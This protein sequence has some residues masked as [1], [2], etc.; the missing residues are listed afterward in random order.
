M[1][2]IWVPVSA[3][4]T[5]V[6][7]LLS[8]SGRLL[9]EPSRA[10]ASMTSKLL[11]VG[12]GPGGAVHHQHL[13]VAQVAG[14][15]QAGDAVHV[16][17]RFLGKPAQ[18]FHG[19]TDFRALHPRAGRGQFRCRGGGQFP[20][21]QT[22]GRARGGAGFT[23]GGCAAVHAS[24]QITSSPS[25]SLP[26]VLSDR[27]PGQRQPQPASTVAAR[28]AAVRAASIEPFSPLATKAKTRS[29]PSA[30]AT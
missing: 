22:R 27:C 1:A 30:L 8:W 28:S 24:H 29:R 21:D 14:G 19:G 7:A 18:L 13:G 4:P 20:V 25:R 12:L 5:A 3:L 15:I 2:P 10:G 16:V 11:G 23:G 26:S 17:H 6:V 9:G